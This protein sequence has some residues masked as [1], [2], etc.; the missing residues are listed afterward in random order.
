M[1]LLQLI[2]NIG[3]LLLT[4]LL[5]FRA[6]VRRGHGIAKEIFENAND[7][8]KKIYFGDKNKFVNEYN[9]LLE[10]LKTTVK[11]KNNL[12]DLKENEIVRQEYI[13]KELKEDIEKM[14]CLDFGEKDADK[15]IQMSPSPT[16]PSRNQ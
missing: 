5:A 16:H 10:T 9:Q 12:L 2:V 1:S 8:I 4:S 13:I 15:V 3:L 14:Q 6:G 11:V 7:E